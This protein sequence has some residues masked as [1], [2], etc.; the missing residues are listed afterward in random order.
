MQSAVDWG[1]LTEVSTNNN[2]RT[3]K[4][5]LLLVTREENKIKVEFGTF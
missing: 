4:P 3:L 2:I 1:R 5:A